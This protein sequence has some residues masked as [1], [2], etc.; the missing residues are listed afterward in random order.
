MEREDVVRVLRRSRAGLV[1]G[2]VVL[3][4]QVVPPEP[5]VEVAG[6]VVCSV[7]GDVLLHGAVEA[8]DVVDEIVRLGLLT[9]DG[10]DDHE[11][12]HHYACGADLVEHFET[13]ERSIPPEAARLLAATERPCRVREACRLRRLVRR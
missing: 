1:L 2:G 4:L 12:L 10:A 13:K 8:T 3:D 9:D 6:T 7:E 11:V 5:V